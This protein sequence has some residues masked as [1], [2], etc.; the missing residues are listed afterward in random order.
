MACKV[1]PD[2]AKVRHCN[3]GKQRQSAA[4]VRTPGQRTVWNGRSTSRHESA[5]TASTS[6]VAPAAPAIPPVPNQVRHASS[7]TMCQR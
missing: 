6:S 3:D 4:D 1:H 2:D 5:E 7:T